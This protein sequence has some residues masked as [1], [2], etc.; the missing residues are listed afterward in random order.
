MKQIKQDLKLWNYE[1]TFILH[2]FLHWLPTEKK[3]IWTLSII[4][5]LFLRLF[6]GI[7]VWVGRKIHTR[8]KPAGK[9]WQHKFA[10]L[11]GVAASVSFPSVLSI[12]N[13]LLR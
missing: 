9:S 8:Y 13:L 7:P 2:L 3:E 1:T 12:Y 4:D 5:N 10:V 6:A 11:G